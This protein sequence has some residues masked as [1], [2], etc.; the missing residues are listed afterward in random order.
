MVEPRRILE[1][2]SRAGVECRGDAEQLLQ[3]Y[4]SRPYY[5]VAHADKA[6]VKVGDV[7]TS[8]SG[9]VG[10]YT[11]ICGEVEARELEDRSDAFGTVKVVELRPR[12]P[13]AVV[14]YYEGQELVDE[15]RRR[16]VIY[17]LRG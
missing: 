15:V 2:A 7:E 10:E 14:R 8:L 4:L 12:T 3:K 9:W 11:V 13:V 1:E 17:V 16:G 5:E 6:V